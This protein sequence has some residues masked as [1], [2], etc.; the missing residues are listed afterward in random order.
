MNSGFLQPLASQRRIDN[1]SASATQCV[2]I[3]TSKLRPHTCSPLRL[4]P[5]MWIL[6]RVCCKS[7]LIDDVAN[8]TR[9]EFAAMREPTLCY[10]AK[11]RA[12]H[13]D[14]FLRPKKSTDLRMSWISDFMLGT[15]S[16]IGINKIVNLIDVC[17][18]L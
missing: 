16:T 8:C 18:F 14:I 2:N 12:I 10:T 5:G 15:K 6:C 7:L 9:A 13:V 4:D 11:S 3:P 17:L 1:I